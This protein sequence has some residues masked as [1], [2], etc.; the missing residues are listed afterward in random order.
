MLW[1]KAWLETRWRI[2]MPMGMILMML[3]LPNKQG[4]GP[5]PPTAQRLQGFSIFW[6]IIPVFLAGAGIRTESA[7]R[8]TKGLHGSMYFTLSLP[9]SRLRLLAVRTGV[10]LLE[11]AAVIV[12]IC[13][14]AGIALP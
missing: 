3:V 12:A 11:T 1:Y 7:F 2:L 6:M 5:P 13:C 14:I 10:G 4:I 9:V 8:A